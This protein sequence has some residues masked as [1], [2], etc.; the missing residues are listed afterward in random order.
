MKRNLSVILLVALALLVMVFGAACLRR[1][2]P[3]PSPSPTSTPTGPINLVKNGDFEKELDSDGEVWN[4]WGGTGT[5]TRERVTM[6]DFSGYCLHFAVPSYGTNPWDVQLT[7]Q[8]SDYTG[9]IFYSLTAGKE[10]TIKFK[11]KATQNSSI[12]IV[13]Q[14]SNNNWKNNQT[15]AITTSVATYSLTYTPDADYYL[16]LMFNF[17][18]SAD[19]IEFYLD[20]I[21]LSYQP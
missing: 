9:H 18:G 4:S 2:T 21:E 1:A 17:G 12:Q 3:A 15:F 20:D 16:A 14:D 7:K 11:A 10:Y 6:A 19:G 13:L 5:H 8:K